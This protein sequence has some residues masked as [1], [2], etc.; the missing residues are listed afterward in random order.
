MVRYRMRSLSE[1]PHE[2][3][4]QQVY[5]QEQGHNGQEEQG[6]SPEHVEVYERTHQGYSHHRRRRCSRRRLYRIHRRRH[7]SC[8]RRRRRSCRHR[9]RHRR[10]CRTRR[11]RCR[12]Y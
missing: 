10:G 5:G 2:V 9:R 4:G 11:R 7:R 8:R 12:R 6:L 1:R 3:H